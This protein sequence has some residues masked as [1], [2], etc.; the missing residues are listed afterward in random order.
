[1]K[2]LFLGLT[3]ID[4]QYII[5]QFP[6]PDSNVK[7]PG[8]PDILV[9]GPATNAAVT[10]SHLGGRAHLVSAFGQNAFNPFL[11]EEL[12]KFNIEHRDLAAYLEEKPVIASV[13]TTSDNGDRTIF[14]NQPADYD[15]SFDSRGLMEENQFDFVLLDGFYMQ[16]AHEVAC[17]AGRRD[18]PVNIPEHACG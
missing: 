10:Y 18:I 15:I 11:Q 6:A 12:R 17:E 5:D 2:G 7:S 14:T 4:I 9:G 3:T 1:M 8:A 16:K 13:V